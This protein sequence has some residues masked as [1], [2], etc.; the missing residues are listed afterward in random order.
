[1]ENK[2]VIQ[3][4]PIKIDKNTCALITMY[5]AYDKLED[6]NFKEGFEEWNDI[7][8]YDNAATQFVEQLEDRWNLLFMYA[9][10]EEI[11]KR[12]ERHEKEYCTNEKV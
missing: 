2:H 3:R 4:R 11:T 12:I 8:T 6:I 9:L 7:E 5:T 10:R 1:M